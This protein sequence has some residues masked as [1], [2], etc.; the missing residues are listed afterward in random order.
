MQVY[1]LPRV[2]LLPGPFIWAIFRLRSLHM[3]SGYSWNQNQKVCFL[4]GLRVPFMVERKTC[5]NLYTRSLILL[6]AQLQCGTGICSVPKKLI[7]IFSVDDCIYFICCVLWKKLF[8]VVTAF[9]S[10]SI[11][12]LWFIKLISYC[13]LAILMR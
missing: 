3:I 11:D 8:A 2:K 6:S 9:S 5:K 12:V 10:T 7:F 1:Y 13:F 4:V